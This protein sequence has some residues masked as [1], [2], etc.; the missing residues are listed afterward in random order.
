VEG[1]DDEIEVPA[2]MPARTVL[3]GL[4]LIRKDMTRYELTINTTRL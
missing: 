3:T 4:K 2:K 1:Q